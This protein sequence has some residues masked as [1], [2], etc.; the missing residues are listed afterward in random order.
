MSSASARRCPVF[1]SL[2]ILNC[3]EGEERPPPPPQGWRDRTE[4]S[5]HAAST[6][7]RSPLPS[8]SCWL[9]LQRPLLADSRLVCS[10]CGFLSPDVAALAP[11]QELG[12]SLCLLMRGVAA[13]G[14]AQLWRELPLRPNQP[15]LGKT[16]SFHVSS[17]C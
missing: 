13:G 9:P 7:P 11:P 5:L 16:T 14:S 15:A 17:S 3:N 4:A 6:N 8:C 1:T 12:L 2:R 10:N